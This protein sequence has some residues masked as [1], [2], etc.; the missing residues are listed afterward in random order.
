MHIRYYTYGSKLTKVYKKWTGSKYCNNQRKEAD[1][2]CSIW[3]PLLEIWLGFYVWVLKGLSVKSLI[4]S[5][6]SLKKKKYKN[7]VVTVVWILGLIWHF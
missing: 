4:Q 5:F 2:V 3:A 7:L 1:F 6:F